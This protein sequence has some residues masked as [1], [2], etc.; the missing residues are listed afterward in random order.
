MMES[1]KRLESGE[2]LELCSHCQ[3][4]SDLAAAGARIENVDTKGGH[5]MAVTASSPALIEKIHEHARWAK[6]QHAAKAP[7]HHCQGG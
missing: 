6:E 4:M 2:K 5:I 1:V 3:R 7:E